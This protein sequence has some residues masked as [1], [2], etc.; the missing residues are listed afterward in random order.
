MLYPIL[1]GVGKLPAQEIPEI[2]TNLS[3]HAQK[4][5]LAFP[6]VYWFNK[7]KVGIGDYGFAVI[8]DGIESTTSSPAESRSKQSIRILVISKTKD[9]VVIEGSRMALH[10]YELQGQSTMDWLLDNLTQIES[11]TIPGVSSSVEILEARIM[12]RDD[13]WELYLINQGE[14]PMGVSGFLKSSKRKVDIRI[15]S[16]EVSEQISESDTILPVNHRYE[17]VE[18]GRCRAAVSNGYEKAIWLEPD[19]DPYSRRILTAVCVLLSTYS[20]W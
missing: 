20:L 16:Y 6:R 12:N 10:E 8:K 17:L 3:E 14:G 13:P 1:S 4:I 15:G 2:R 7:Y 9:S 18:E 19:L 5:P 11:E